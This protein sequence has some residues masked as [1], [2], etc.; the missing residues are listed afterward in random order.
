MMVGC[1]SEQRI[2]LRQRRS[3]AEDY[4]GLLSTK[5]STDASKNWSLMMGNNNTDKEGDSICD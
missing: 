2:D 4:R 5:S 3:Q 1:W